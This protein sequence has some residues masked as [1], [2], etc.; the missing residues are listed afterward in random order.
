MPSSSAARIAAR[1][2]LTAPLSRADAIA[3]METAEAAADLLGAA[4]ALRDAAWGRTL[5]YSPKVFLPVTNLCRDRCTYCTFRKDPDDPDAWTMSPE[6]VRVWSERGARLGCTEALMCLGDKPEL[7]FRS[8]RELLARLGHTS[9]VDYLARACAIAFDTGLLP[10][11]NAGLLSAADM[12]RLRPLNV[13]MG[14]MLETVAERLRGR[15]EVH[16]WAPDKEP[17]LRLR[18]LEDAGELRIPF[19]TGL[20]LGIGETLAERVDTLLAIREVH[21]RHGHIQEVIVQRFRAKPTIA[22]ADAPD[23]DTAD[24]ARTIAVARLVL[25]PEVSVQAPPNLS[26]PAEH[27]VLIGAGIN[28]WGGISPLTPDYVNPEA[29]WPH[30]AA[31]EATCAHA[32]YALAPRLPIYPAFAARPEFV[33]EALRPA[34]ERP[35][36][37][38][39]AGGASL[40]VPA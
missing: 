22:R 1:A 13:S 31:L 28:D 25:D 9:T 38:S 20:L 15:G 17:R 27:A 5:T 23:P 12:Q 3:L 33:D 21:R 36:A 14:L 6:D 18:M 16:Q 7:A 34:L 24:L 39:G 2:R 35:L 29:P 26:D 11:T 32:G 40:E 19:T 8:Y 4:A 30:V 37:R 10:H